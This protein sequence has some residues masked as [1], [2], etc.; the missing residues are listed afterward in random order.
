MKNNK[1]LIVVIIFLCLSSAAG[2]YFLHQSY[3]RHQEVKREKAS[4]ASR[5]AAWAELTQK[6]ADEIS[7]FN[8]EAGIVIKDLN[9]VWEINFNQ[10]KLFPSASV[11]KVP[12]M[13]ACFLAASEGK[14]KLKR[15]VALKAADKFSGSGMLKHMQP[16]AFFTVKKLIGLMIYDSDNTATNMLT[17]MLGMDYLKKA[18]GE[19][20]LKHTNLSRRIAD[21]QARDKGLENYTSAEDMASLLEKIY[22]RTLVNEEVSENCLKIL[23][24]QRVNDRIPKYLPPDITIAHKT[25]LERGVCHDVGIVFSK[26]DDF[27]I[28]VLTK[29]SNDSSGPSKELIANVARSAWSYFGQY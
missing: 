11:A 14:L 17:D 3:Q 20:G 7:Q 13:A 24:L 16:G 4:L 23:K 12:I 1:A 19:F 26:K 2:G 28:C 6:I 29:H 25:G 18:F 8:G 9:R 10:D 5:E 27:I 21:F 15:T 22:R